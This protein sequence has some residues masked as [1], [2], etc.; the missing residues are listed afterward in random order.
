VSERAP[1]AD[2]PA[3]A[4][5]HDVVR[6]FIM[7][8]G[9]TK[10]TRADLRFE[11]LVQRL[12]GPIPATVPS[13]QV[14]LLGLA[15]EPVSVAELAAELGLVVGVVNVLIN[16]LLDAGRLEVFESDPDLIELDMLTAMV[17]KIRSL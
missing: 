8:R 7:T 5:G 15:D 1:G 9:R 11:T 3:A 14:A 17:D 12:G 16:D 2:R 10:V 6:P 13:E 4:R